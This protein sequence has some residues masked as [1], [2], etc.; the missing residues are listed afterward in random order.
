M[1]TVIPRAIQKALQSQ[2]PLVILLVPIDPQKIFGNT[3]IKKKIIEVK[4]DPAKAGD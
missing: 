2:T 1:M 4:D 3:R